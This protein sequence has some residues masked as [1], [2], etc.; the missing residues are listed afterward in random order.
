MAAKKKKMT[1]KQTMA[2]A[3]KIAKEYTKSLR[4]RRK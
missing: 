1:K 4:K 2:K 3:A